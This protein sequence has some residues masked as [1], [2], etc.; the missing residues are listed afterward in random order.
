LSTATTRSAARLREER[1]EAVEGADVQHAH[2]AEI[3]GQGRDPV[4]V[5]TGHAVGVELPGAV[6]RERMKPE[7]HPI[8]D[9]CSRHRIRLDL[10]QI[11]HLTLCGSRFR[12]GFQGC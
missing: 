6:E 4:A 3:L 10:D 11:S 12:R 1:V 2:A 8:K 7:W 9:G 5:I